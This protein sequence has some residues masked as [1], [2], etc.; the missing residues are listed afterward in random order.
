M[1]TDPKKLDWVTSGERRGA[2]AGYTR[3]VRIMRFALPLAA[4]ALTVVII[5]WDEMGARMTKLDEQKFLPE[6]EEARGEMLNP[7]FD[8]T[9][10]EGRPFTITAQRAT[11]DDNNP[12]VMLMDKPEARIDLG[13]E[14][15]LTS[16]S[17]QG[18]Y[19]QEAG[20]LF[21]SSDVQLHH[22]SG[23]RLHSDELRLD[24]K[25]GEAF[26]DQPVHVEGEMGTID[27]TGLEAYNARGLII[28][29]GPATLILTEAG[30]TTGG[31]RP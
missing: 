12:K 19:E 9:D 23:Y 16:Q 22:S 11:Q 26:S 6:V 2:G 13:P 25:T 20:K 18:V 8:S 24:L 30:H 5:L 7:Q 17:H 29:K 1:P 3:F 14:E 27:A 21:L 10:K 4:I 15:I 28:F 31:G